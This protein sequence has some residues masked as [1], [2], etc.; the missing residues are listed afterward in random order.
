[1]TRRLLCAAVLGAAA[2][3][4]LANDAASVETVEPRAFGYQVG[5]VLARRVIVHAAQGWRLDAAS[6]PVAGRRGGAL[7]L[8]SVQTRQAADDG[9]AGG[10]LRYDIDLQYQVFIAPPQVRTI[11]IAPLKI[12]L[13]NAQR[14]Q[15]LRIEAWP[16]T[17]APLVP[18]D[19]PA[20]RGLGD[21][22]P[23]VNPPLIDTTAP[24]QRLTAYAV[25]AA[26]LL[27]AL[28]V[29]QFGPPWRAARNRPF[30]RALRKLRRLPQD[31]PQVTWRAACQTMHDALNRTAG[32]ALF[33]RD[34]D[35]FVQAHPR[36][37]PLRPDL[38]KFLHASRR[39]FFDAGA[40]PQERDGAWLT[41]LA[42]RC[43]DAE[44]GLA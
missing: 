23:D 13:E 30:G 10:G 34:L 11:E 43:H 15:T 9:Q 20:R 12:R 8:R 21:L 2:L 18:V 38:V 31:V 40:A 35:A 42:R 25:L 17:V 44:R 6:L 39:E 19:A 41:R 16:V 3:Q 1:M 7:E 33:E 4:A 36:F 28:A 24:R 14:E 26:C 37:A 27:A 29:L 22:Q 5:D 32:H